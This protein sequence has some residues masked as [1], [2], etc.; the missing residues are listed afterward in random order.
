MDLRLPYH[1]SSIVINPQAPT[2]QTKTLFVQ[3]E[4]LNLLYFLKTHCFN[5]TIL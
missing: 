1:I 5:G 2:I 4:V 3:T